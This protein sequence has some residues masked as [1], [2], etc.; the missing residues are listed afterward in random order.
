[1]T[2]TDDE[3]IRQLRAEL[4][5]LVNAVPAPPVDPPVLS[6]THVRSSDPGGRRRLS[7]AVAAVAMLV[8]VGGLIVVA[9]RGADDTGS[10]A[11]AATAPSTSP[12]AP[13]GEFETIAMVLESPEHGPQLCL[14][15]VRDSYPPQCF[16]PD[17][18][19]WTWD[20]V[21]GAQSASGTTWVDEAHLTGSWDAAA[22]T[23]TVASARI[24]TD[25]DRSRFDEATTEPD[26]SVPCPEPE[27]GWP[28]RN[29][30]WPGEQVHLLPGYAGSWVD[31]S[32][33][34][35]TVK[36]TGDLAQAE[37]AVRQYY[38]DALC[39]APAEHTEAELVA[40]ANQL[41]SMSSVQFLW[42]QVYVDATGE[43]LE[44]GVIAP[45]P[46]RQAG[47]DTAYGEGVVRLVP[48][49]RPL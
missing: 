39:V 28:A 34:V 43:W 18:I 21:E 15:A 6:T 33:Q 16:G 42:N 32:Q 29:Q 40:I 36:F 41:M 23:F 26:F 45:D 10:D 44:V 31:A 4:D 46:D 35:M 5:D 2:M 11:P 17:V 37:A 13:A 30:E 1:M 25:A 24:A 8:L 38:S 20:L 47:F 7:V 48:Q 14:G 3:L 19:N 9:N 12:A 49:L 22:R 27:G